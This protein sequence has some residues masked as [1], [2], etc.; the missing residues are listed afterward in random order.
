MGMMGRAFR[1]LVV[2]WKVN[3][4]VQEKGDRMLIQNGFYEWLAG[5]VR[6]YGI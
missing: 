6:M 1:E 2:L 5:L 3:E 4:T